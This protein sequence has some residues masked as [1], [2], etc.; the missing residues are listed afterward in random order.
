MNSAMND[1]KKAVSFIIAVLLIACTSCGKNDKKAKTESVVDSSVTTSVSTAETSGT[2]TVCTTSSAVTTA[3]SKPREQGINDIAEAAHSDG[4]YPSLNI[5]ELKDAPNYRSAAVLSVDD[6]KMLF[7]DDIHTHTAPASLTKLLTAATVLKYVDTDEIFTVGSEQ[8]LVSP[9]S[10]M[11]YIQPG[12]Q[13]S[14]YDLMTGMLMASG[15]DAAY[16]LAVCTARQKFPE[17]DLS[18][19]EAADRFCE[20]M[21]ETAEEIGMKESHFVTPDGWDDPDH[22]T[23]V[24][25]LLVL[26]EYVLKV[27]E[28]KEITGT[29]TKTVN[30]ASG[31]EFTWTNSNYLLDP[32]SPYYCEYAVG[33]K[34]GTTLSAGNCLIAAIEKNGKTYITAV[35]GCD[36][37]DSRYVLTLKLIDTF[38]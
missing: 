26:A 2:Y 12:Q 11:A 22:Y 28:I 25:D 34:T 21:N 10:S 9:Y 6:E 15:N 7:S 37:D 32:S 4:D 36:T 20:L 38:I 24:N 1:L 13:I 3:S 5:A 33:M 16:T 19:Q 30:V 35:T 18:D 14:V 17:E 31:D 23:T 29:F 8:A 27:P